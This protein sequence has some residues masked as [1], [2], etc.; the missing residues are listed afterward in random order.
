MIKQPVM[1]F[2]GFTVIITGLPGLIRLDYK[3]PEQKYGF[4]YAV[5]SR[6]LPGD[7]CLEKESREAL[8]C[9]DLLSGEWWY[10]NLSDRKSIDVLN[11]QRM[12][13]A[14][15]NGMDPED[16]LLVEYT[17]SIEQY[18]YYRYMTPFGDV[19]QEGR[20]P[21]WHKEHNY[22]LNIYPFVN[23]KVFNFVDD[24]IDQQKYINRTLTMIDFIRSSTAKR[25]SHCG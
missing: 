12:E 2:I 16:V 3:G 21:Y 18:W 14:L 1:I 5:P 23:G 9:R 13:E 15:A 22:I 17:Y 10:S 25:T 20:S 19:L 8:F 6:S 7:S 4:L 24:F 11:K